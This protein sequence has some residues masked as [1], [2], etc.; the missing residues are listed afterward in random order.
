[1]LGTSK[2]CSELANAFIGFIMS[3]NQITEDVINLIHAH[4]LSFEVL[5]IV[6]WIGQD[7]GARIMNE[8][9]SID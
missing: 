8:L 3:K 2:C 4:M 1:M 6:L 5:V 7:I 9:H